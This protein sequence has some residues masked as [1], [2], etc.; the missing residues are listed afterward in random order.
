MQR[1]FL[2]I[3]HE[4][5]CLWS[6]GIYNFPVPGKQDFRLFTAA[7]S[8]TAFGGENIENSDVWNQT[9]RVL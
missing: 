5:L 6:W 4:I 1:T 9:L 7:M 8:V 2:F 3:H